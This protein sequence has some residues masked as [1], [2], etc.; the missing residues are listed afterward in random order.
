MEFTR[1]PQADEGGREKHDIIQGRV[2]GAR[3]G[4]Q[5]VLYARSGAWWVQ[6]LVSQ[7]FTKIARDSKWSNATHLGTEYAALLVEPH[8]RPPATTNA[9]PIVGGAVSAVTIIKGQ[10]SPPSISISFSGYEWRVRD[11][12]SSRGGGNDYAPAN[13]WTDSGGALHLR[14]AKASGKWTCAEVSLT[15][16]LGYGTYSFVVRDT[17]HLEPAA[18][19]GMFTWDYSGA[20]QNYREV[21]I[22]ISH[23]GDPATKNAQYVVQPYYVPANVARFTA[24]AGVLTHSFH[25][26]PGRISF[27]TVRGSQTGA[28]ARTAAEHVFTSGI[29]SHGIESVRMN[30][31]VYRSAAVSLE[32]GA[33]VVIEKF[34]YLP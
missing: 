32:N 24:P 26:E 22:E 3:P 28:G 4:Q 14:I 29:P 23:W 9:L 8:Y 16:S 2:A 21:D 33:E 31:Y 30:L 7:P 12:P 11:A 27:A 18:V 1:V 25:W 19:F 34:E 5:I 17:S 6:P 15:R 10:K 13:A 20:D